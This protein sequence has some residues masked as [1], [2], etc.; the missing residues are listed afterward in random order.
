MEFIGMYH[1]LIH[2]DYLLTY[3]SPKLFSI[4]VSLDNSQL[5]LP[6]T[7]KPKS[8]AYPREQ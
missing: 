5:F 7:L 2:Q 3:W 4:Q 1:L 8:R 6:E